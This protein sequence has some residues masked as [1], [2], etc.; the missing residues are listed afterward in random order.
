MCGADVD[1]FSLFT[2]PNLLR[3]DAKAV[4]SYSHNS[5]ISLNFAAAT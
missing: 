5:F 3:K 2:G 4:E 1:I